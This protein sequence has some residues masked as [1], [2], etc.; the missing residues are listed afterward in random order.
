MTRIK[1]NLAAMQQLFHPCTPDFIRDVCQARC[2][3]STTDPTG[4]AVV[5]TPTEAIRLRKHG[6]HIDDMTG[7]VAH[8]ASSPEHQT[9]T[10]YLEMNDDFAVTLIHKN[11]ASKS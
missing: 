10:V 3:R 6:A 5:V 1:V 9:D 4:I 8:L 11:R 2:C 7:R